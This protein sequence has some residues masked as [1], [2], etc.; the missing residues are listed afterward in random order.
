M[1]DPSPS[2]RSTLVQALVIALVLAL[3]ALKAVSSE[4]IA[5]ALGMIVMAIFMGQQN[6]HNMAVL[7]QATANSGAST[8]RMPAVGPG[9]RVTVAAQETREPAPLRGRVAPQPTPGE[10]RATRPGRHS[11]GEGSGGYGGGE[12]RRTA[13][14]DVDAMLVRGDAFAGMLVLVFVTTCVLLW[15]G[16]VAVAALLP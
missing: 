15:Y 2:W 1:P 6:K 14:L 10:I 8:P 7:Q 4:T 13:L 12:E 3:A 5:G 11:G 16:R 9:E